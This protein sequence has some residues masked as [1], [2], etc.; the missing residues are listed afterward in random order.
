M[1]WFLAILSGVVAALTYPTRFGGWQLPDLGFLAFVCWVPL[2]QVLEKAS[3]KRAFALSFVAAF[4][5]YLISKYWLYRA[6]NTFGGLSPVV[7]VLVLL[8]LVLILSAYFGLIFYLSQWVRRQ[9]GIAAIWVRP[10]FWVGIE[11]LRTHGPVEGH[12]WSQIAYSQGGFLTFIQ[13]ADLFGVYAVTLLLVLA[14]EGLSAWISRLR[15]V[16]REALV[17]RTSFAVLAL[18][19]ALA[20]GGFRLHSTPPQ[21][22]AVLKVGVVQGNIPQEEKW[23][24]AQYEKIIET[25]KAG[26]RALEA[27]GAQLILWPEASFPVGIDYDGERLPL[28]LG[29]RQADLLLGAIT[30]SR[31]FPGPRSHAPVFNSALLLNS[32][33]EI[34]DYYHKKHLVPLG[35]YVPYAD[36]LV[37]AKRLTAEVGNLQAGPSFRPISYRGF[38]LGVLICYEDIFPNI[39]RIMA[40]DGALALLNITNDAWYG[41]SSAAAQHQVFSQFRSVE[42]RRALIRATN[43]GISS[44]IDPWGHIQWQGGMYQAETFLS[45]LPLYGERSAYVKIGDKLPQFS[46][47]L[48]GFWMILALRKRGGR[49]PSPAGI[50]S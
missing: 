12:P 31:H 36:L 29:N 1:G 8:F 42:T 32:S 50:S 20:Y 26:T 18:G 6:M 48:S 25:Y 22:K 9:C 4:F 3:P 39:S 21:P 45:D 46:L 38:P 37:F 47:L 10:F 11:Y 13:V 30:R 15:G 16:N 14:N 7:S 5:Q 2:F 23:D 43:T 40:E 24:R 28:F 49:R 41:F 34:L 33:G 19:A 17:W 27:R 44:L 35:E